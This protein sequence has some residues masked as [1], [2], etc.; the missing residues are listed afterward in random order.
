VQA[1]RA[2]KKGLET[3]GFSFI[4]ILSQCPTGYGR[5]NQMG[6]AV[7][8]LKWFKRL[9]IRKREDPVT[10]SVPTKDGIDLGEFVD[11]EFPELTA[12]I[13]NMVPQR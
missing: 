10:F 11:R 5:R 1:S 4:E 13:R 3:K 7:E 2:I 6:D 9:P 12:S 8:M